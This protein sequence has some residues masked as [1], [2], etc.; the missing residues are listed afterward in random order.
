MT[1][2]I[3]L[4]HNGEVYIGA[5]SAATTGWSI[6]SVIWPKIFQRDTFLIGSTG[7]ARPAQI[8]QYHL[9]VRQQHEDESSEQYIACA[10]IEAVRDCLKKH[11]YAT[12]DNNEEKGGYFLVGYEG[13]LY[14]VGN[15]YAIFRS[16]DGYRAIGCGEEYAMGAMAALC[17]LEPIDRILE[18]LKISARFNAAVMG[19]FTILKLEKPDLGKDV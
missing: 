3:G 2:I 1:C 9:E 8:L 6:E 14:Y 13:C 10:F 11:G 16:H 19:P 5:D 4:E 12:V 15:D 7:S 18:S 17:D